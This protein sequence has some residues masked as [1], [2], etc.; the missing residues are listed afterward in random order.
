MIQDTLQ[1]FREKLGEVIDLRAAM[2]LLHWDLE[3]YMPPKAAPARGRQL[4]TLAA[5]EHRMFTSEEMGALLQ[6][7]EDASGELDEDAARLKPP[8]ISGARLAS[9]SNLSNDSPRFRAGP[10]RRGSRRA[11]KAIFPDFSPIS[12]QFSICFANGRSISAMKR[13]PTTP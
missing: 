8:T 3:V 2:H 1:Q 7:L 10:I 12:K 11:R 4:A 5:L 9:R 6:R 13:R